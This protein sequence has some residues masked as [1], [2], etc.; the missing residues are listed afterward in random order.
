MTLNPVLRDL[1]TRIDTERLIL[2]CPAP[3]DGAAVH[4]GVVDS[5]E[6]LRRFPASLPW[7]MFE[8]SV[9]ASERYCREGQAK[10]LMRTEMPLLLF[11]KEGGTYVGGSG[12]HAFDWAVPKCETGYWLRAGYQGRGLAVEAVNAITTWALETLGMRRIEALPDDENLASC[13]VCERAGY[14]LEGV[15][16]NDRAAPDGTLR[17][18]RIYAITR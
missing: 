10:F 15:L 3:G 16:R 17:N 9:D 18:T 7:A 14:A 2:R 1:P 11:L 4:A 8:P 5:L 6:A 13:R 12:L